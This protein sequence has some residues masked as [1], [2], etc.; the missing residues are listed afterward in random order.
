MI[1]LIGVGA[2]GSLYA[3]ALQE[4]GLEIRV[5]LDGDRLNRYKAEPIIF[6]GKPYNFDYFTPKSGDPQAELVI[7]ATKWGGY[8][9]ALEVIAPIVGKNTIIL[10]LLNG[11]NSEAVAIDK[12][13]A[14][15]VLYGYYIGHTATRIGKNV[16]H[17]GHY[18]TVFGQKTNDLNNLSKPVKRVVEIF[19]F[20]NIEYRI[21]KDLISSLWQKFVINIGLNQVTAVLNKSYGQLKQDENAKKLMIDLMLEAQAIAIKL[22]IDGADNFVQIGINTLN[23]MDSSHSSSMLQ[24][25]AARRQTEVDIFAA[26]ICRLGDLLGIETPNNEMILKRLKQ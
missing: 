15:N 20:A 9:Q 4:A 10:P 14:E 23:Q 3:V 11:I 18:C 17:N 22:G 19:D 24:D 2:I 16:V 6:N 21:D 12:F 1:V 26:Q 5:A 7:I 13:G 8:Q 25:V